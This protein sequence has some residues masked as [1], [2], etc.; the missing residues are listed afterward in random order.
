MSEPMA[1]YL[2]GAE[3]FWYEGNDVGCLLVHGF[4]GTPYEMRGLGEWLSTHYQYTISG[5]A[6]DGHA[7][8]IGAMLE[9]DW[10]DWYH[11]VDEAYLALKSRCAQIF[12]IGLSL[13]GLLT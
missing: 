6:L 3:P 10:R 5:P 1:P 9:T 8:H 12:C 11:S 7:T 4:T 2:P 13:G